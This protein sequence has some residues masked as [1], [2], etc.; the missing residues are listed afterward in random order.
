MFDITKHK[1]VQE[2]MYL[3]VYSN[4]IVLEGSIYEKDAI[5]IAK[6]F[7]EQLSIIDQLKFI[8]SITG[9]V[10]IKQFGAIPQS[11]TTCPNLNLDNVNMQESELFKGDLHG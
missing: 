11:E 4:N 7:Y 3:N 5:A 6:H 9:I 8:T 2:D 10:D 1:W